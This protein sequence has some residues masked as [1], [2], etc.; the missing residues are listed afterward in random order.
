MTEVFKIVHENEPDMTVI[1][2]TTVGYSPMQYCVEWD[3]LGDYFGVL[4]DHGQTTTVTNLFESD[5]YR[6]Y[7]DVMHK[8]D[9][10]VKMSQLLQRLDQ[11]L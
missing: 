10:S 5:A 8:A 7:L 2:P 4:E 1:A 11:V 6:N 9:I 3:K